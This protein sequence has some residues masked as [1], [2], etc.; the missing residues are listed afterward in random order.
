MVLICS[1]DRLTCARCTN[2][3]IASIGRLITAETALCNGLLVDRAYRA[4]VAH[5]GGKHF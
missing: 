5:V 3:E 2:R 4:G 1:A